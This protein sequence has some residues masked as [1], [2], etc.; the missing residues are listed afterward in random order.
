MVKKMFPKTI[1]LLCEEI[2]RVFDSV[3]KLLFNF[4]LFVFK[5]FMLFVFKDF[6]K[7]LKMFPKTVN[8]LCEEIAR[9]FYS[10][11]KLL[12]NFSLFVFKDCVLNDTTLLYILY[13]LPDYGSASCSLHFAFHRAENFILNKWY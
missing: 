1:N 12:F 4:M 3:F 5:D 2:A 8:L 10:V 7:H 13:F 6:R 11:F 9:V